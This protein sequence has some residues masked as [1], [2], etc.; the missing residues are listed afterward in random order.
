VHLKVAISTFNSLLKLK[1]DATAI[2][3]LCTIY[4]LF[5]G[6]NHWEVRTLARWP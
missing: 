2:L 4:E 1:I 6:N 5:I 3:H